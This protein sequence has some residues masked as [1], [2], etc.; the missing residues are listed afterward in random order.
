MKN[1]DL[2][3]YRAKADGGGVFRFF[4]SEMDARMQERRASLHP[5]VLERLCA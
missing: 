5:S 1:A 4:E 2:A 3:L